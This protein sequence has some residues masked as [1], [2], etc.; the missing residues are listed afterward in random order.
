[1]G[2]SFPTVSLV[3]PIPGPRTAELRRESERAA[4]LY[5]EKG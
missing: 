5:F 3:L 2:M 1:M 4:L